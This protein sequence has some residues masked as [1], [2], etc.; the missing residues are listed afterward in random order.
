[1]P[2]RVQ[3]SLQVS[4]P[5]D[6]AE[7]EAESTAR[8]ITGMVVPENSVGYLERRGHGV[9][10]QVKPEEK[11]KKLQR[12]FESPYLMRFTASGIFA[13]KREEKPPLIQRKMEG[14][15][16]VSSN[17]SAEIQNSLAAGAPLPLG[18]RRFMEPRFRADFS[19][20]KVHT[21]DKAAKLN[22]Q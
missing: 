20:V 19:K 11:E 1:M 2:R 17:V 18:V 16:N 13:Q 22:R 9:F 5:R 15:P 3:A 8:K 10:R 6:S 4:S 12:R 14:Q 7:K 21:S